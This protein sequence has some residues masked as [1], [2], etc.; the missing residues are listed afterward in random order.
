MKKNDDS[1]QKFFKKISKLLT[2][3][4]IIFIYRNDLLNNTK[5]KIIKN[6]F[7]YQIKINI[8]D[9]FK[10]FIIKIKYFFFHFL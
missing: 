9:Q 1:Y 8:E 7:K 5:K 3:L 6:I 4:I 10:K 2:D